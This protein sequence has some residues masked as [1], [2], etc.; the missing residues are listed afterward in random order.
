MHNLRIGQTTTKV[1]ATLLVT[2]VVV[3][4]RL[5]ADPS[6]W[7][8]ETIQSLALDAGCNIYVSVTG[9]GIDPLNRAITGWQVVGGC[10]ATRPLGWARKE[11]GAWVAQSIATSWAPSGG[12]SLVVADDGTP[13]Y[14]YPAI[15]P[16]GLIGA[17]WIAAY[18][19]DLNQFPAG[20]LDFQYGSHASEPLAGVQDCFHLKVALA[21]APGSTTPDV[22]SA[23][24]CQYTGSLM[25]N[26]GGTVFG[27]P[28]YPFFYQMPETTGDVAMPSVAI[29]ADGS[30]HLVYYADHG[31]ADWGAYYS[32]GA[33][34]SGNGLLLKQPTRVGETSVVVDATTGR[35]HVA[36]G[37]IPNCDN[38]YEGGLLYLTSTDGVTWSEEW[39]DHTSGRSPSI[40]LDA[41]GQPHIA[42][43]HFLNEVRYATRSNGR[44]RTASVHT[45]ATNVFQTSVRLAYDRNGA[46]I[47]VFFDPT[48]AE[49]GT[50]TL[51]SSQTPDEGAIT[52]PLGC[53]PDNSAPVASAIGATTPEDVPV[54]VALTATDADND[55]LTFAL[56]SLTTHGT[57]SLAGAIVTYTPAPNFNGTDAFT[58]IVDD[59]HNGTATATVTIVVSPVND[60]P[61]L[62]NP[63]PQTTLEG[64]T[65]SLQLSAADVDGD[66]LTFAASG[67]P[68]GLHVSATGLITGVPPDTAAGTYRVT[69]SASDGQA[70]ASQLLT[71]TIVDVPPPPPSNHA[72]VC[73]SAAP[74]IA[75]L[76]PP[77]H[78]LVKVG[79]VGVTDPDHD[80]VTTRIT[81]IAQDEPT[82]GGGDGSTAIDGF[83]VGTGQA[84]VRA[85]RGGKGNG[86][87]Y[88]ITFVATDPAGARCTGIVTV[89]VPHDQAHPAIGDGPLYDSTKAG[90]PHDGDEHHG[91]GDR[92]DRDRDNRDRGRGRDGDDDAHEH[93]SRQGGRS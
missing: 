17:D 82:N 48:S 65:V 37:A 89:G 18:D 20:A 29:G 14:G 9:L 60:P 13:F 25:I 23:A 28:R 69:V 44:W 15:G 4:A 39:V 43:W 5:R 91:C 50:L 6:G 26:Y 31:G 41:D 19:V 45:T 84:S 12:S 75:E 16:G 62:T 55:P 74:T 78:Q 51:A 71:W 88:Y 86:R 63:G 70:T 66:A 21:L 59:G 61:A 32:T 47:V 38:P 27:T 35:I 72:P 3:A 2:L 87:M 46:A 34:A 58:F 33:F 79:I 68:P 52:T 42:Y 54:D 85:E 90:A 11:N 49:A 92:E 8:L 53:T 77:N 64:A 81:A 93:E 30:R 22:V 36:L 67:L 57:A 10:G 80:R 7:S 40:A 1:V 83:G 76:W 56:A 24:G 73:A